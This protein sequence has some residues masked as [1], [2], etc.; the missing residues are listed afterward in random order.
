MSAQPGSVCPSCNNYRRLPS[1]CHGWMTDWNAGKGFQIQSRGKT[2]R[3]LQH[4]FNTTF[5]KP[6]GSSDQKRGSYSQLLD[7]SSRSKPFQPKTSSSSKRAWPHCHG[8]FCY[9]NHHLIHLGVQ[10]FEIIR[11]EAS[12]PFKLPS[13]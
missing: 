8:M 10:I 4:K 11:Q 5:T 12:R 3:L 7:K 13:R 9:Q 2:M 6:S 1:A